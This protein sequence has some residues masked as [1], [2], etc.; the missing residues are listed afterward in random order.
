MVDRMSNE[1]ST[2]EVPDLGGREAVVHCAGASRSQPKRFLRCWQEADTSC[3]VLNR[4]AVSIDWYN[5]A[6]AAMASGLGK[7]RR[8]SVD[9]DGLL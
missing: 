7:Q 8:S 9:S 5:K 2:Q 6:I 3:S 1:R 4:K